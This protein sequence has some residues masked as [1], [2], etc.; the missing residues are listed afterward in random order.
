MVGWEG[1]GT[2]RWHLGSGINQQELSHEPIYHFL[3]G[4]LGQEVAVAEVVDFDILD[5]I[6]VRDVHLP[7]AGAARGGRAARLRRG[8]RRG[9]HRGDVDL[10][11][12][13][14]R[15]NLG[16]D[17]RRRRRYHDMVSHAVRPWSRED[18]G[19][20]VLLTKLH[21]YL[22]QQ[23]DRLVPWARRRPNPHRLWTWGFGR[24]RPRSAVTVVSESAGRIWTPSSVQT[25]SGR[26]AIAWRSA[27]P[28][29]PF[30]WKGNLPECLC[31]LLRDTLGSAA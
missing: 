27:V 13:L 31:F 2:S 7:V 15:L 21:S 22:R 20:P 24:G 10:L 3:R 1:R 4:P 17:L 5:I 28:C 18:G 30:R 29:R 25:L 16:I 14:P 19:S 6:A 12:P 26:S 11:N 9:S 23:R 8:R